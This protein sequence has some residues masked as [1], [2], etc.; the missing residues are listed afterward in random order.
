[1]NPTTATGLALLAHELDGAD[2]QTTTG[3]TVHAGPDVQWHRLGIPPAPPQRSDAL[4]T[5]EL[6]R[7]GGF[8]IVTCEAIQPGHVALVPPGQPCP[9]CGQVHR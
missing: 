1:M 5:G 3:T 9:G 4:R 8:P 2:Q 7:F 6:G